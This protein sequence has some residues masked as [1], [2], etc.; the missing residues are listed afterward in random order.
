MAVASG[1]DF[2]TSDVVIERSDGAYTSAKGCK[3]SLHSNQLEYLA[4]F[5][6][7]GLLGV[8]ARVPTHDLVRAGVEPEPVND[9]EPL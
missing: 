7:E 3:R 6:P 5:D 2:K 9:S 4:L 1:C 8:D